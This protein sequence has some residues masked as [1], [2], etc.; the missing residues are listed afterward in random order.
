MKNGWK[1]S[2]LGKNHRTSSFKARDKMSRRVVHSEKNNLTFRL[3]YFF[4]NS[5][6]VFFLLRFSNI[7]FLVSRVFFSILR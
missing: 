7:P 4:G 2:K 3:G 6:L 1:F 5:H